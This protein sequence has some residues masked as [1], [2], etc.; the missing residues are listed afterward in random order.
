MEIGEDLRWKI[1][2]RRMGNWGKGKSDKW[3]ITKKG[4][5]ENGYWEKEKLGKRVICKNTKWKKKN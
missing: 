5:R 2:K 3:E 1:K 4:Y